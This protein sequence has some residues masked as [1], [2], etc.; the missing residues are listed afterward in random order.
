MLLTDFCKIYK[1]EMT[2]DA[3][4]V[5][6]VLQ[7]WTSYLMK[8]GGRSCCRTALTLLKEAERRRSCPRGRVEHRVWLWSSLWIMLYWCNWKYSS[9]QL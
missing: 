2:T 9:L 4:A 7:Q 3:L 6:G 5:Y 8:R 1:G